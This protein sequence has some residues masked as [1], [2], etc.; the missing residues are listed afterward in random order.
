MTVRLIYCLDSVALLNYQ[1]TYLFGQIQRVKQEVSRTLILPLT[2]L[3]SVL[4]F[5]QVLN[6][7]GL[8]TSSLT[9]LMSKTV[10]LRPIL[11]W[12]L[13]PKYCSSDQC[14]ASFGFR[15]R[16]SKLKYNFICQ[17]IQL[18]VSPQFSGFVCANYPAIP[19]SSPKHTLCALIFYSILCFICRVKR[20]KINKKRSGLAYFSK[21][22][23]NLTSASLWGDIR[24]R[25]KWS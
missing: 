3:V 21:K 17:T 10:E 19:G 9:L 25:E 20:T 24:T 14:S 12:A 23:C 7:S 2:K 6:I 11:K 22:R 13:L 4:C 18:G 5:R 16:T 8:C 15:L 1:Q